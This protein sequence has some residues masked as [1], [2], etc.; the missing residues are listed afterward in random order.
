MSQAEKSLPKS[1]RKREEVVKIMAK[2][3]LK[4]QFRGKGGGRQKQILSDEEEEWLSTFM[5][6]ADISRQTPGRKDTVFIGKMN[7]EKQYTQKRYLQWTIRELLGII[8]G[9]VP[10]EGCST[11]S[12]SFERDLTFRQLYDF[13]KKHKQYKFSNQT[14]HESCTCEICE[15]SSLFANAINRKLKNIDSKIPNNVKDLVGEYSCE[16]TNA[17]CMNSTCQNCPSVV[18]SNEDFKDNTSNDSVSETDEEKDDSEL[19]YYQWLSLDGKASKV[20]VS[21]PFDEVESKLKTKIKELKLHIYVRNEQYKVYNKL[22]ME[23]PPNAIL[24]HVDYS[25]SYEN[26]QQDECQSAYFGHSTFSIFTAA[27]YI[28]HIESLVNENF[29]LVSE[30]KDHSRIAAHSCIVKVVDLMVEKHPY[31]NTF[32][33]IDLH[34]WSDG[35][36]AQFRSKYVFALTSLFPR[37]F[38]V[39]R[40]YNE[41]HH[42]KGPM[43]GIGGCVKNMVYRAVMSG[44]EVIKTPKEFAECADKLVKGVHC[45]YQPIEEIMEEP[46]TIKEAPYSTNMQILKVHKVQ[47]LFTRNGFHCAQLFFIATDEEPF[48]VQWYKKEDGTEPCGHFD[49]V[50]NDQIETTCAKCF[51]GEDGS[52]WINCPRCDQWFHEDCF[53]A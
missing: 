40:Y 51:S 6:R 48:Y 2:K 21:T 36:S 27:V 38:N 25:E 24:V 1:P 31:L 49:T 13:I 29:V 18:L 39:T 14:P 45:S 46:A 32:E 7:G 22:K 19:K 37:R 17:D 53:Y 43:D 9:K 30:A 16:I 35:C 26:K 8:N 12:D 50:E 20:L 42:G 33:S 34:I 10:M 47:R 41:R 52:D 11:F 23:M 4:I 28:R 15:N 3:F 44:R 5:D